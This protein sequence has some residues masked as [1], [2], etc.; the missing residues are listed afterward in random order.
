MMNVDGEWWYLLPSRRIHVQYRMSPEFVPNRQIRLPA[1]L[2]LGIY[3]ALSAITQRLVTPLFSKMES[4]LPDLSLRQPSVTAL[5]LL[6]LTY[7]A[8]AVLAVLPNTFLLK[9]LLQPIFL[10]RAW[11]CVADVDLAAWLAQSLGL[12]P[13]IAVR[14]HL[15]NSTLAVRLLF[16]TILTQGSWLNY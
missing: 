1:R 10:W 13:E 16:T 3:V 12:K 14:L 4:L 11:R 8:L 15:F 2:V 7:Y 6:F 9:L 5:I